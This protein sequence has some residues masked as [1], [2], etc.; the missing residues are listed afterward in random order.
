MIYPIKSCRG[1]SLK[2]ATICSQGLLHDHNF[3]IVARA[4]ITAE[5]KTV[6]IKSCPALVHVQ[7][8]IEGSIM[9]ITHVPSGKSVTVDLEPDLKQYKK[10]SNKVMLWRQSYLPIDLG[11]DLGVFFRDVVRVRGSDVRLCCKSDEARTL[12]GDGNLPPTTTQGGKPVEASMHAAFPLL[13]VSLASLRQLNT[14]FAENPIE[15]ERFRANIIIDGPEAWDEDNWLT[16]W[17]H[18]TDGAHQVHL[19]AR[20]GRC[21]VTTVDLKLAKLGAQ[22]LKEL[23]T[24]R[25]IDA[26]DMPTSPVFGMYGGERF[27][28]ALG[29]DD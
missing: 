20:C 14:K 23:R 9:R 7:P 21:A 25:N 12:A 19:V 10:L 1:L 3:L 4:E 13:L 28:D 15:V 26:G 29:K 2:R 16:I 17:I 24:Y 5:W 27:S 18:S 6:D 22:P 11:E 8:S